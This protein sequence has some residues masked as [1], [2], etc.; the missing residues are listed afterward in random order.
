MGVDWF[1]LILL[2]VG[3]SVGFMLGVLER[4]ICYQRHDTSEAGP[5]V[6]LGRNRMVPFARNWPVGK[7]RAN[8]IIA[9]VGPKSSNLD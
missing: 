3:E 5:V 8:S 7:I 1:D 2:A 4:E 9:V 6:S